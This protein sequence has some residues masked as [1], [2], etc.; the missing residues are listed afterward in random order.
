[1]EKPRILRSSVYTYTKMLKL[2][3]TKIRFKSPIHQPFES[4]Q[5]FGWKSIRSMNFQPG[6]YVYYRHFPVLH[7]PAFE[8]FRIPL[9]LGRDASAG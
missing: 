4:T 8:A 7:A 5:P 1:M 3:V 2:P 9:L 6:N